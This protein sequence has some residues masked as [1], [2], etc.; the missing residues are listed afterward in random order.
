MAS[1]NDGILPLLPTCLPADLDPCV[2]PYAKGAGMK[3]SIGKFVA[4][5]AVSMAR[6]HPFT[7]SFHL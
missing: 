6:G 4:G 3:P 1:S 7:G 5:G 2:V